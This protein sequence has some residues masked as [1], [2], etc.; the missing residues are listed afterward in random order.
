MRASWSLGAGHTSAPSLEEHLPS[1][2]TL[3]GLT[4]LR[5]PRCSTSQTSQRCIPMPPPLSTSLSPASSILPNTHLPLSLP[6]CF[7]LPSISCPSPSLPPTV[8]LPP[9]RLP[10]A[11][12]S[13]PSPTSY[14]SRQSPF[15]PCRCFLALLSLQSVLPPLPVLCFSS[16][17]SPAPSL[18]AMVLPPP[19][20]CFFPL[21]IFPPLPTAS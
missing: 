13:L 18:P 4:P 16:L 9:V 7:V 2:S 17:M 1:R 11:L 8:L 10:S 14:A 12:H 15:S 3:Q 21:S 5:N 19:P 20:T 6:S